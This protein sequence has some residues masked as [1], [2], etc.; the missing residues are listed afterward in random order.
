[1]ENSYKDS[2]RQRAKQ[3]IKVFW[4]EWVLSRKLLQQEKILKDKRTLWFTS[5]TVTATLATPLHA[6]WHPPRWG[7]GLELSPSASAAAVACAAPPAVWW[8]DCGQTEQS[9]TRRGSPKPPGQLGPVA[10]DDC[11]KAD[12]LHLIEQRAPQF[13][14]S[15]NNVSL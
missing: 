7:A 14:K 12:Y 13:L 5:S 15:L 1:M 3:R 10:S 6:N 11:Q 4:G 9:C 2:L 8:A